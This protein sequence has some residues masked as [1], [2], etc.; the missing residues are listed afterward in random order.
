VK[1]RQWVQV[2]AL[3]AAL[4]GAVLV[5]ALDNESASVIG[6]KLQPLG[7]V[8]LAA[9]LLIVVGTAIT[10]MGGGGGGAPATS[11]NS[12][13]DV[14]SIKAVGGLIAVVCGTVLVASLAAF[15]I[16][17]LGSKEADSAVAI[18]SSAFGVISAVVGAYLGIKITA[19]TSARAGEE[20]KHTAVVKHEAEA[21]Q[22]KSAG[23][24][25]KLEELAAE[26]KVP[27]NVAEAVKEAGAE[28][29]EAARTVGPPLGG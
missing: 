15:T 18:A 10:G 16:T 19:D 1:G 28:A 7:G 13:T 20:A 6:V 17:R 9:G 5:F 21:A 11:S 8:L 23:M 26:D 14:N 27:A 12:S 3:A 22:Q 24:S 2:G 25:E 29:E 4:V